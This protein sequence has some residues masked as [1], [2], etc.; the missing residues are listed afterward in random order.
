[1]W[2]MGV[3]FAA[4]AGI[5]IGRFYRR[6]V[7]EETTKIKKQIF[8][9]AEELEITASSII[10]EIEQKQ[11]ELQKIINTADKKIKVLHE[12]A[13]SDVLQSIDERFQQL[14]SSQKNDYIP[15]K[16]KA[17][18]NVVSR[19]V[20]EVKSDARKEFSEIFSIVDSETRQEK[21]MRLH[22]E[23]QTTQ[24]IARSLE[25]NAGEVDLILSLM[26]KR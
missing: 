20:D 3:F 22:G 19:Q 10:V 25:M 9:L 2:L 5:W 18:E 11:S 1:M 16:E 15:S 7:E 24:Q 21:I 13:E 4:L 6:P 12:I 14:E 26:K 8:S 17:K 23:G